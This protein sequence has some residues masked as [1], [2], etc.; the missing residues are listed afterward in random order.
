[1]NG[2][3]GQSASSCAPHPLQWS[4]LALPWMLPYRVLNLGGGLLLLCYLALG[5]GGS[6]AGNAG[7]AAGSTASIGRDLCWGLLGS[8]SLTSQLLGCVKDAEGH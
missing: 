7:R 5:P 3:P 8:A 2:Y 6:S 4:S 1:M